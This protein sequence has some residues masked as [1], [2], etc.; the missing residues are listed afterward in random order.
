MTLLNMYP[1]NLGIP[2]LLNKF[3]KNVNKF[4]LING[5]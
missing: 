1:D 4:F 2:S 5:N 3:G